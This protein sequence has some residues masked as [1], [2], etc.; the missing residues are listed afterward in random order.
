MSDL[1]DIVSIILV[2]SIALTFGFLVKWLLLCFFKRVEKGTPLWHKKRHFMEACCVFFSVC[3]ACVAV[4][5]IATNW[6]V[7]FNNFLPE[8]ILYYSVLFSAFFIATILF[9]VLAPVIL[10]IYVIYCGIFAVL[11]IHSYS[12][13][14]KDFAISVSEGEVVM[15]QTVTLSHKNLLPFSRYWVSDPKIISSTDTSEALFANSVDKFGSESVIGGV[16]NL[17]SSLILEK[18]V[19]VKPLFIE[20][21]TTGTETT[22]R[23][24]SV[25]VENSIITSA[26]L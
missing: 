3:I 16:I 24:F 4:I 18:D 7:I 5:L 10:G 25:I 8:D 12:S 19:G 17:F 26:N 21:N 22:D 11:F 9:R 1:F 6:K 15:C 23:Y 14:P 20:N 13:L 2:I